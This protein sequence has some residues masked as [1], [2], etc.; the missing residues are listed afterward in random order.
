M[1]A[2]LKEKD[3]PHPRTYNWILV[4]IIMTLIL[5]LGGEKTKSTVSPN[6]ESNPKATGNR[7]TLT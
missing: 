1:K 3:T 2:S 6:L 4:V 5:K 7:K